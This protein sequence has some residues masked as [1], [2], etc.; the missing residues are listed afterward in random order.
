MLKWIL[1]GTGLV[2]I[3]AGAF[4]FLNDHDD[5]DDHGD[6]EV[7]EFGD[8]EIIDAYVIRGAGTSD[9][10]AAFF[11]IEND[12]TEDDRLIEARADVSRLVELH[13]HID[14]NGVMKMRPVENGFAIP[15]EGMHKLERG[16]DHV[17]FM[18]VTEEL[19]DG[20]TFPLT[21]VFEK[22]GEVT[23]DVTVGE[24]GHEGHDH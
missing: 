8:L 17:M 12:G 16:A 5:H 2:A 19:T 1:G 23:F 4:F 11:M 10:A 3:A 7:V 6:M 18:G 22:A 9:T 14:E 20:D 13:T 15:A 21:L 24:A